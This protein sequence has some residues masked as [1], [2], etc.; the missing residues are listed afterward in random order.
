MTLRTAVRVSALGK[1]YKIYDR[2]WHRLKDWFGSDGSRHYREF[3]ALQQVS[4]DIQA[5][6]CVGIIGPNG[7]GK[8]TLLK[9]LSGALYATEGHFDIQGRVLSILELGTG[10]NPELTGPENVWLSGSLLG[11]PKEI[12]AAQ[13]DAI[14]SFADLGDFFHRPLKFYSSG[15]HVRLAFAIFS[16]LEPEVLILDEAL[17]VGDAGFQRKCY[18]RIESLRESLGTTVLLVSHDTNAIVNFC[19]RAIFIHKGRIVKD[20]S[21]KEVC[22]SYH[23]AIFGE[24]IDTDASHTYGDGRAVFED[25]WLEDESGTRTVMSEPGSNLFF[26]F[27]ILFREAIAEP[28]YGIRLTN[29]QGVVITGSNSFLLGTRA[30]SQLASETVL[31]RCALRLPL[32]PGHYFFSCGCS[33]LQE[34]R[35]LCRQIDALRL[36][37]I[38][39]G[40]C[41]GIVESAPAMTIQTLAPGSTV[42]AGSPAS[43]SSS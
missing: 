17:A 26:C 7:S 40:R 35:F 34:D 27:R 29:A 18:R 22:E 38:G 23:R 2:P 1:R 32:N 14:Q 20:G 24:D 39:P 8:S 21:P 12:I 30:P 42:R 3:W 43:P 41:G 33:E 19:S 28:I 5:G 9:I 11:V 13:L 15:M 36:T 25:V 31:V 10:F 6:E 37:V 16:S 4:F